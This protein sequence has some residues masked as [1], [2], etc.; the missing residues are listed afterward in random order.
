MTRPE[1][2]WVT[3]MT[4]RVARFVCFWLAGDIVGAAVFAFLGAVT[5]LAR[6]VRFPG[7][8]SVRAESLPVEPAAWKP[9]VAPPRAPLSGSAWLVTTAAVEPPGRMKN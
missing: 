8:C 2:M 7:P 1:R 3:S 6:L 5:L 9:D 4:L